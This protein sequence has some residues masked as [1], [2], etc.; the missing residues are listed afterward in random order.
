VSV[1]SG[2][3]IHGHAVNIHQFTKLFSK[4]VAWWPLT[5]D[6]Q[7]E[8]MFTW[9]DKDKNGLVSFVE[10]ITGLNIIKN[11][12]LLQL[13]KFAFDLHSSGG[14]LNEKACMEAIAAV[15]ALLQN[16]QAQKASTSQT[17]TDNTEDVKLAWKELAD[18]PEKQHHI[19]FQTFQRLSAIST[20]K[21]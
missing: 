12:V 20:R 6:Q 1:L 19:D 3:A 13:Q 9:F 15:H 17:G 14:V 16:Q 7:K 5:T 10:Y 4:H 11:G 21:V 2:D 18:N 8:N